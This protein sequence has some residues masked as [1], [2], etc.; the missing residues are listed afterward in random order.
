MIIN[1]IYFFFYREI[2]DK[3]KYDKTLYYPPFF[4]LAILLLFPF[5][6]GSLKTILS[7]TGFSFIIIGLLLTSFLTFK[8]FF[9][10][11]LE[12]GSLE[13]YMFSKFPVETLILIKNIAHWILYK[14]LLFCTIPF[15]YIFYNIPLFT[16]FVDIPLLFIFSLT[17]TFLGSI[18]ITLNLNVQNK[19]FAVIF[20]LIPLIIPIIIFSIE[21]H[22]ELIIFLKEEPK[23]D[24]WIILSFLFKNKLFKLVLVISILTLGITPWISSFILSL[25][26]L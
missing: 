16:I 1:G 9:E 13:L 11:D 15:I 2:L 3:I 4:F 12:D 18:F 8:D 17:I 19:Q 10:N 23:I 22:N 7:I 21:F 6:F 25:Y 24:F 5:C 26:Y 14:G 20:L